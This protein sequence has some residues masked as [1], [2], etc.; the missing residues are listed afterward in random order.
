[1][2]KK[3]PIFFAASAG[4]L[5]YRALNGYGIFNKLRFSSEHS[6]IS[7]YVKSHHPGAV[8]GSVVKTDSGFSTVITDCGTKIHLHMT[9]TKNGV[10][11]F[12]E[13]AF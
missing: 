5:A 9:V 11:V 4:L 6:A 13:S 1:M 7:R 12:S 2:K 3:L 8:Y 10:C